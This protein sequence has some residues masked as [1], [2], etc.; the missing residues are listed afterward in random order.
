[1]PR[2]GKGDCSKQFDV[3]F[4]QRFVVGHETFDIE[5]NRLA[6]IGHRFVQRIA[7]SMATGQD[8]EEGVIAAVWFT[9]KNNRVMTHHAMIIAWD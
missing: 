5:R 7:L 2:N 1:M 6:S 9:V 8:R 4:R 3:F